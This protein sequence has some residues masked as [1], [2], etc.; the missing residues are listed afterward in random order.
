[1]ALTLTCCS[2]QASVPH[3]GSRVELTMNVGLSS[4]PAPKD[5][6]VGESALPLVCCIVVSAR[7]KSP[8]LPFALATSSGWKRWP[9]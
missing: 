3:L 9:S 7:G 4:E 6:S 8:P 1:M 2:T 5:M